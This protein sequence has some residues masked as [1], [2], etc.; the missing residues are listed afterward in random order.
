MA[1]F[2]DDL[3]PASTAITC[4]WLDDHANTIKMLGQMNVALL[5]LEEKPAAH[6]GS[7]EANCCLCA[8]V[9]SPIK[10]I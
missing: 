1:Q 5:V 9:Y 3:T 8:L 10:Y 6:S 4:M 7:T 2:R